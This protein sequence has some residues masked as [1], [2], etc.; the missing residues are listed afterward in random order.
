MTTD[1][2]KLWYYDLS[3]GE[4][5]QGRQV[6]TFDRIGPYPDRESA[7]HALE[8]AR[9]RTEAADAEDRRWNEGWKD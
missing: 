1:P 6:S 7:Q 2:D 9:E 5:S 3:T 4:V 8:K